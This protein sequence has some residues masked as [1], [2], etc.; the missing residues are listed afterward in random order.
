[1]QTAPSKAMC[2]ET[3][4]EYPGLGHFAARDMTQTMV[5]GVIKVADKQSSPVS[6]V[7][8]STEVKHVLCSVLSNLHY[9]NYFTS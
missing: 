1:M 3:S 9:K 6:K 8:E 7:P 4:S 5:L 2:E